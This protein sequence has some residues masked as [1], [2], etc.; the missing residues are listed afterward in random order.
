MENTI[1][2]TEEIGKRIRE[3]IYS[4][5]ENYVSVAK[6]LNITPQGLSKWGAGR[7]IPDIQNATNFCKHFNITLD[8]LMLGEEE[9]NQ[10]EYP[11]YEN[12]ER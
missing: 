8:Y 4:N 9:K 12:N 11:L 10:G 6:E 2:N 1:L 3:I 5:G 7:T